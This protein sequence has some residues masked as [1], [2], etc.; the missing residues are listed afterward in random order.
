MGKITKIQIGED[1]LEIPEIPEIP[2][3]PNVE[4]FTDLGA[5]SLED[6]DNITD[7]GNY[8]YRIEWSAGLQT[9]ERLFVVV[10]TGTPHTVTQIRFTPASGIF[11]RSR[12][13]NENWG[14]W[15]SVAVPFLVHR[16][17][18]GVPSYS[19][20]AGIALQVAEGASA[21]SF[22]ATRFISNV[23]GL[24]TFE[25]AE[26]QMTSRGIVT[27]TR[28]GTGRV[29]N[30]QLDV[31]WSAWSE[32]VNIL[33]LDE[34]VKSLESRIEELESKIANLTQE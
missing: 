23:G 22:F 7:N 34:K 20:T 2:E 14:N 4:G 33:D 12:F 5:I 25:Q 29:D 30:N 31:T 15:V 19:G 6:V 9:F 26:M 24:V 3:F 1:W 13:Q 18:S 28:T 8:T 10:G 32:P 11:T 16:L 27:R 17:G 21:S